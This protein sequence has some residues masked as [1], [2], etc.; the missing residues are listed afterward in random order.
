MI[1]IPILKKNFREH[2]W[3][4]GI[5]TAVLVLYLFLL[6]GTYAPDGKAGVILLFSGLPSAVQTALGAGNYGLSLSGILG[7]YF[8]ENIFTLV[9]FV[10]SIP[11]AASF[12]AGKLESGAFAWILSAPVE[13]EKLLFTQIYSFT[14]ALFALFFVNCLVGIVCGLAFCGSYFVISEFLLMCLGGFCLHF[15]LGGLLFVMSAMCDEKALAVMITTGIVLLFY[16]LKMLASLGG[17]FGYLKY[18]TIF[19]MYLAD[20]VIDGG[21]FFIWKYPVLILAGV[22]L[23]WLSMRIFEKR[24]LPL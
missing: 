18:V 23:Y 20:D 7:G 13:R 24:D 17:I 14:F 9:P 22:L 19:S 5:V 11:V 6:L 21:M 2:I 16:I 10:V 12:V 8:W 4:W 3:L 1:N 15:C